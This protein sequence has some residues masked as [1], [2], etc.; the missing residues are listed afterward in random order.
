[1]LLRHWWK[2]Q[3]NAVKAT[4]KI[5]EVENLMMETNID[6]QLGSN[7]N[8]AILI[9]AE[10]LHEINVPSNNIRILSSSE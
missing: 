7:E 5:Y 1:M 10:A 3:I 6:D 2:Q 9:E 4:R 8:G